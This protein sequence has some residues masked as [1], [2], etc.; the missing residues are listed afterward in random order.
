[1]GYETGDVQ[2]VQ[3]SEF[4]TLNTSWFMDIDT[5]HYCMAA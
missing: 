2:T 1:M 3:S 4:Q 5:A